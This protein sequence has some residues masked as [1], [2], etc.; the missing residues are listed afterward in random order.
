MVFDMH[1]TL[2]THLLACLLLVTVWKSKMYF[3]YLK[4]NEHCSSETKLIFSVSSS[5]IVFV[6][7]L[8]TAVALLVRILEPICEL[9]VQ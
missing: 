6:V 2:F 5:T 3:R 1:I 4:R 8:V 9:P 7:R